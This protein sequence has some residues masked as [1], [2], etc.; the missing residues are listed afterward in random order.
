MKKS[1]LFL[2]VL[3]LALGLTACGN[4]TPTA[5]SNV[6]VMG[7]SADYA[8]FE[9][10]YPDE[11]GNMQF[12]G[13]DV[14]AGE[15]IAECM[16]RELQ[17]E[18]MAFDY[19]LTALGKGDYDMVLA[20][21]E[22]TEERRIAA[23]F[24]EPYYADMP[25][26]IV[27]RAKNADK[28]KTLAD[29]NGATVG[30]QTATTKLDIVYD[31]ISGANAVSLQNVNDLINELCYDKLD[32]VVLDGS[33]AMEYVEVNPD[34]VVVGASDELGTPA[35]YVVA[36]QKYDP[37]GLLPEINAAVAKMQEENMVDVFVEK[38]DALSGVAVEVSA[39]A[40]EE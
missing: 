1:V 30:A 4:E 5:E 37:K 10:M 7:T 27:A 19:L 38:A 6:L 2:P 28:Y 17:V 15:Y 25:T 31:E 22:D 14:F 29:L 9:F 34:L 24:S 26:M 16:G 21:M 23:D 8:P 12:G 18:N 36:V 20:C 32:A 33:V 40:P 35:Y 11:N 13:I 3:I 39:D